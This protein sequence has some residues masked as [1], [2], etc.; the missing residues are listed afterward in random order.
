MIDK[1]IRVIGATLKYTAKGSYGPGINAHCTI[2][3]ISFSVQIC[4]WRDKQIA[5][6]RVHGI[7][8]Q[9][10]NIL[11]ELSIYLFI[12][13]KVPEF[14]NLVEEVSNAALDE[15]TFKSE[16]RDIEVVYDDPEQSQDQGNQLL[17]TLSSLSNS[18]YSL[19]KPLDQLIID[20]YQ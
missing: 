2:F 9:L 4:R 1:Q 20:F 13:R 16:P 19:Y 3:W 7:N 6:I 8:I 11:Q 10:L 5:R 17:K 18:S 15:T 12:F 14:V